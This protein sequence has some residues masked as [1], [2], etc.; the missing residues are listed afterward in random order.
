MITALLFSVLLVPTDLDGLLNTN[1]SAPFVAPGQL[2]QIG[3]PQGWVPYSVDKDPNAVQFRN[4]SRPGDA[5]LTIRKFNVPEEARPR[6]LVL[7][8][9]DQKLS[10]LPRWRTIQKRDVAMGG[11]PASSV[12]GSYA[13]QANLQYPRLVEMV[14]VTYGTEA[15]QFFFECFEG[16][17]NAFAPELNTFYT[18]FRPRVAAPSVRGPFAAPEDPNAGETYHVADPKDI[19]F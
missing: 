15:Y 12:I 13:Y 10:K 1:N 14:F 8:A 7:N 5:T 16:S 4:A 11:A 17:A 6:Q 19:P 18:S 2:F 9:I 3:V